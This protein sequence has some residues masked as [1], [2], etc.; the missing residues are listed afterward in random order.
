MGHYQAFAD[1][2]EQLAAGNSQPFAV[3]GVF[4]ARGNSPDAM[5]SEK[6]I[7]A[8]GI[9]LTQKPLES[10]GPPVK[11]LGEVGRPAIVGMSPHL[12]QRRKEIGR[13]ARTGDRVTAGIEE[14]KILPSPDGG[15]VV[16]DEDGDVADQSNAAAIAICFQSGPL[17]F[18]EPLNKPVKGNGVGEGLSGRGEG[19]GLVLARA[20]PASAPS[21]CPATI[22]SEP[23]I[24]NSHRANWRLFG[25]T[26]RF[27][28]RYLPLSVTAAL[29]TP[30][31]TGL[32]EFYEMRGN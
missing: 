11:S 13:I 1:R 26:F 23:R 18:E 24:T 25:R 32:C 7:H 29:R 10:F 16:G 19:R 30:C 27:A 4:R 2:G 22:L 9:E 15:R 21:I 17:A 12:S 3:D 6:M 20:Q 14:E 8:D 31:T 5:K 28:A